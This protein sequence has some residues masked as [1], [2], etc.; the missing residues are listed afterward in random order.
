MLKILHT[1]DWH[2]GKKLYEQAVHEEH[3]FFSNW[4]KNF[5][6]SEKV[7]VLLVSGD[8][9]DHSNPTNEA[10][11]Q[12]FKI[13]RSLVGLQCTIIITGGNHDSPFVLDGPKELLQLLDIHLVGS[14]QGDL[15]GL[16]VPLK[17]KE[18]VIEAVVAALPFIRDADLRQQVLSIEGPKAEELLRMG[19]EKLYQEV[20][21]LCKE[22]YPGIPAIAM[23]H[24]FAAGSK[25]S[26]S[27]REIQMGNLAAVNDSSFGNYFHYV[28]LGH[29]HKPQQVNGQETIQYSGSPVALS[30]SEKEDQKRVLL[31]TLDEQQLSIQSVP[32]PCWRRLIALK[33]SLEELKISLQDFHQKRMDQLL[34]DFIEMHLVEPLYDPSKLTGLDELCD[35]FSKS[36][37]ADEFPTAIIV[38]KRFEFNDKILQTDEL[39]SETQLLKE[40]EPSDVFSKFIGQTQLDEQQKDFLMQLFREMLQE[41]QQD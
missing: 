34:P 41:L 20:A 8:V 10:R 13:L 15:N 5:I 24:L 30:F 23:G 3:D 25:V 33:G 27:E 9:Y 29:I 18:G 32:L 21:A 37:T 40:L 39:Y 16:I 22:R 19:I 6:I 26:E 31:L 12:Y 11:E 1:A 38:K 28:A 17:N 7:D 35:T 4:L 2:L 14:Y 36:F